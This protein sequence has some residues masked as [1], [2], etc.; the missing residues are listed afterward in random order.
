MLWSSVRIGTWIWDLGL[1]L[2]LD[3]CPARESRLFS[4]SSSRSAPCC[5]GGQVGQCEEGDHRGRDGGY[6]NRVVRIQVLKSQTI[7]KWGDENSLTL[8]WTAMMAQAR[9]REIFW[10]NIAIVTS[11]EQSKDK[12]LDG[13]RIIG[14]QKILCPLFIVVYWQCQDLYR[15]RSIFVWLQRFSNHEYRW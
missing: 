14:Q 8:K 10:V 3:N 6:H 5:H 15:Q 9:L 4:M 12:Y 7:I 13:I 11:L 2:E 1:G